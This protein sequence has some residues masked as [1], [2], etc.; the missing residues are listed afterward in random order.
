[1][2]GRTAFMALAIA[3]TGSGAFAQLPEGNRVDDRTDAVIRAS[4]ER[5]RVPGNRIVRPQFDV[6]RDGSRVV[7]AVQSPT[8]AENRNPIDLWLVQTGHHRETRRLLRVADRFRTNISPVLNAHA[9]K[10]AFIGEREDGAT[11]PAILNIATGGVVW[12]GDGLP[13]RGGT[14]S[15]IS[16]SPDTK[17]VAVLFAQQGAESETRGVAVDVDWNGRSEPDPISRLAI[18]DAESGQ[19]L[20]MTP[21]TLSVDGWG[22]I[23]SWSPDSSRIAFSAY[24][25]GEENT[26]QS[27][28][29]I[30]VVDAQAFRVDSIVVRPGMDIDPI[31]SLD[32]RRLAFLSSGGTGGLRGPFELSILDVESRRESRLA[33]PDGASPYSYQWLDADRLAFAA[34]VRMSCPVFVGHTRS[35]RVE[36]LSPDDLSCLGALRTTNRNGIL[37]LRG[38]FV[39]PAE[40]IESSGARWN[41]QTMFPFDELPVPLARQRVIDWAV[42]GSPDRIHGILVEP[43][44]STQHPRPL[45]VVLTGGPSMVTADTYNEDA[46]HL[47][48][49]ALLRGYAVLIPNTRGRNGYGQQFARRIR[50]TGDFMAGPWDDVMA[51][52]DKLVDD[53]VADSSRLALAGFSYGGILASYGATR[54]QRFRAIMAFEGA[55]DFYMRARENYGGPSQEMAR[56]IFGFSDPYN[57]HERALMVSQSPI[58]GAGNV[59]TPLLLECGVQNLAPTDCLRYLRA[60]RQRTNTPAELIVYPRT[61]H[62]IVEP[63]L[64]YDSAKRQ[65]SWLDRWLGNPDNP[66]SPP[67]PLDQ[68]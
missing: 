50:D 60:V 14:V 51:G 61:G 52:I 13:T 47:I 15:A 21:D 46:Q 5:Q 49:P 20:G 65:A 63:A 66:N 64:R 32:G 57:P 29:D 16:W 41:A 45:L 43:D 26:N 9:D 38:S 68:R 18:L 67:P 12:L 1:M 55:V 10:V 31:W 24:R 25:V 8:I 6:S 17:S 3:L 44:D 42:P 23:F 33:G 48:Q 4:V 59:R 2:I 35:S 53:G 28:T 27:R 22:M 34:P 54:T 19:V 62:L 39:H 7:V 40:L 56:A 37:A 58:E 36:Q 30:F 11:A